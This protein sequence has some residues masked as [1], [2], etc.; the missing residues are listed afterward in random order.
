MLRLLGRLATFPKPLACVAN[1]PAIGGGIGL[2][3]A[4]RFRFVSPNFYLQVSDR[5]C[6]LFPPQCFH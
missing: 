1:G 5:V 6:P 4:C 2:F 3:F